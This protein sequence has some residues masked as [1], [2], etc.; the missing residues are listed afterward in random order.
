MLFFFV[1]VLAG[2]A[3]VFVRTRPVAAPPAFDGERA[4]QDVL[5]QMALGPRL[6]DTEAHARTRAWIADS[7]RAA[8]WQAETLPAQ[9]MG[10]TLYNVA[11]KRG[12]GRPWVIL[13]AHY[14]NRLTAD[15]DPSPERRATPVPGAN[16]GASGVAVLLELARTLPQREQPQIWLVFF[17]GEDNGNIPTWDWILGSRAFAQSLPDLPDAVVVVDMVGDADLNIYMEE[18]SDPR[19]TRQIWDTAAA[20]GYGEYFIPEYK[21]RMLD[22]HIP[23]RQ[24]GAAAVDVID[25]DYPYWH[26]VEDTADKVS[27]H[28]LQVVGDTLLHWLLGL[29][30]ED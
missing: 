28:S 11:G 14:D 20:L 21:Y 29:V 16:D 12:A 1:G 17:D 26:T 23:F 5:Y 27:A 6:P 7:L 10:H 9:A 18:N 30:P 22:D 24:M 15:H 19:V 8:G 13:G 2:A 4:Y 3:A 25:F